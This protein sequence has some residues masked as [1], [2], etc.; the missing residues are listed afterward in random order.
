[1][2]DCLILP[3]LQQQQQYRLSMSDDGI[4]TG[5]EVGG[6]DVSASAVAAPAAAAP[7]EA[8]TLDS[9]KGAVEN[10][11]ELTVIYSD[12]DI[13]VLDKPSGLRTVPGRVV[14]PEAKT[15]AHVRL[16]S[17]CTICCCETC[18]VWFLSRDSSGPHLTIDQLHSTARV[19]AYLYIYTKVVAWYI[20]LETSRYYRLGRIVTTHTAV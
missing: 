14:G 5:V 4:A 6:E 16:V 2:T 19:T 18:A 20:P 17:R 15:R 7:E 1:M 10:S 3:S 9:S 13:A 12:E 8:T 11:G